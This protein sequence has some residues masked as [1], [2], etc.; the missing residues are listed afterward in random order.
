L[1]QRPA[2][3]RTLQ[4]Q[5]LGLEIAAIFAQSRGRHGSPRL[6]AELR[7]RGQRTGHHKS[8]SHSRCLAKQAV[9]FFKISLHPQPQVLPPQL[10]QLFALGAL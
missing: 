1:Q 3:V 7:V 8:E 6:Q 10:Y 4:D 9:A 2:T 5:S